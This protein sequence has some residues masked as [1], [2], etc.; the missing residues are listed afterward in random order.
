MTTADGDMR[1]AVVATFGGPE[2]LR[3]ER[4]PRPAPL[5]D[6][7][8]VRVTACGV[9]GHD[10]LARR[11]QLAARTPAILGHEI[12]GVVEW[13]GPQVRRF[14]PGDRVALVQRIPCGE[15]PDCRAGATN[16]CREGRGFYGEDLPGGYAEC[17]VATERNAVRV[18]ESMA[19]ATAAILSCGVGT[20]LRA[21]RAAEI[22]AGDVVVITGAGGGVGVH[23]LQIAVHLGARVIAVTSSHAKA[24]A[25]SELGAEEVLA[26]PDAPAVRRAAQRLGRPR[27]ADAVI[28]IAGPPTFAVSLA[29]LGPRGRLV[30]VGNTAPTTIALEPGLVI[31][32][33]LQLRGSAHAT[34]TDLRDVVRLVD[35]GA[36]SP[37]TAQ[38]FPL[39][40][41]SAAH[42]AVEQRALVGRAVLMP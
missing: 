37:L 29:A 15:C 1:A 25:L 32:K 42:R 30:L 28:E 18:P 13:V 3:L 27:G 4:V 38:T 35:E 7:M 20:G 21:L 2:E 17:V 9:C 19:L 41:A 24:A 6:E 12:A 39:A 23:A 40:E 5:T 11:G 22:D 26:A 34:Q 36:V 8:L 14:Q 33:E 10:L 16:T 31:V